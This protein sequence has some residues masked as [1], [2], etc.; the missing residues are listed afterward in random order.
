[1]FATLVAIVH[2]QANNT[3]SGSDVHDGDK[4]LNDLYSQ[5]QT[6]LIRKG[7]LSMINL[8]FYGTDDLLPNPDNCVRTP[9]DAWSNDFTHVTGT[10][11]EIINRGEIRY[12][13]GGLASEQ[14]AADYTT[15]PDTNKTTGWM[16]TFADAITDEMSQILQIPLNWT[17]VF[18]PVQHFWDDLL[19]ALNQKQF[20]MSA[21]QV[22]GLFSRAKQ[23]DFTCEYVA[24]DQMVILLGPKPLPGNVT[25]DNSTSIE[26]LQQYVQNDNVTV[27]AQPGSAQEAHAKVLFPHANLT[28]LA[29]LAGMYGALNNGTLANF[30]V[31]FQ[32][33]AKSL[34]NQFPNLKILIPHQ[35]R[36]LGSNAVAVTRKN[37]AK[38][39]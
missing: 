35:F 38:A 24:A 34:V 11:R 19:A 3:S 12:G 21:P 37:V 10:L 29:D 39:H 28:G 17:F 7:V 9:F 13:V 6:R 1:V 20:D 4:Q 18:V 23:A 5:A 30:A 32:E 31:E 14:E 2:A 25:I 15:D 8:R 33:T 27:A 16:P 22:V 36:A 26:Q